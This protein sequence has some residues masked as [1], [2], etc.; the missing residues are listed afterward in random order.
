MKKA[1]KK[2]K[3]SRGGFTLIELICVIAILGILVALAVPSYRG[4][5]DKS[6]SQVAISNARSNYTLGKA[7]QDMID[8]GAM[9]QNEK[10]EYNY[11]RNTD[12]TD[13]AFWEGEINGRTY[14]AVYPGSTG[15]G[16][17]ESGTGK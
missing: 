1:D 16:E 9:K 11:T 14:K 7:Q 15:D 6:A 10:Q 5:Q 4:L 12:G 13:S 2:G 3:G 17:I 8:A